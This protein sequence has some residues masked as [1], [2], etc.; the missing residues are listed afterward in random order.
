MTDPRPIH[1]Q[2]ITTA[3]LQEAYAAAG[4]SMDSDHA[5]EFLDYITA[6][7]PAT[8]ERLATILSD[9]MSPGKARVI[10]S[11]LAARPGH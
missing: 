7:P 11:H 6:I 9:G 3:D 10:A 4:F 2:H 1:W 5:A 8:A